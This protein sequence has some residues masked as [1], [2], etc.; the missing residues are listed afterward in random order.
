MIKKI[1][2]VGIVIGMLAAVLVYFKVDKID[3]KKVNDVAFEVVEEENIP[4]E[5]EEYIDGFGK[6]MR[7][8]SYL[9]SDELYI[10][11]YY[12][13]QSIDGYSIDVSKLYESKD[14]VFIETVLMGPK[15][16][17]EINEVKSYPYVVIKIPI[18]DKKVVFI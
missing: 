3:R 15:S 8:G 2:G 1:I 7:R 5:I 12:G 11:V 13:E 18:N 9:C 14:A 10:V 17:K 4:V 6:E 16:S